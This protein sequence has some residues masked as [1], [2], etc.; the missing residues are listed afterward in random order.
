MR[1]IPHYR[2]NTIE[3]V[4]LAIAAREH[5]FGIAAR[6]G[7]DFDLERR[8]ILHFYA[9]RKEYESALK[10][11]ALLR[12]G[13][14]ERRSVTPDEIRWLEPALH[15][16]FY[17]GF[18]TPSDSTGDIHKFTR[19]LADACA[20][21]DVEF[22]Y[23]TAVQSIHEESTGRL[24]VASETQGQRDAAAFDSLVICAGVG[25]RAFAAM[26]G[27]HVNVYPVKGYSITVSRRCEEPAARALGQP[28]RRQREDRHVPA[29]RGPFSRRGHGGTERPQSRY[30]FGPYRAARAMDA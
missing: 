5:L 23:D 14:L 4:R 7:I 29:R 1:Q 27:D 3:T 25:S 30:P 19:G 8:G 9:T 21:H 24:V 6:E 16:E 11:N 20:P 15:G 12:E 28:A 10:V 13:G 18:S 2:A 22:R 17:G 26:V